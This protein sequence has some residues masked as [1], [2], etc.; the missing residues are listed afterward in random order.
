MHILTEYTSNEVFIKKSRFLTEAF[1]IKTQEKARECL[2]EQ[3]KKYQ[4]ATHVVHAFVIGES[5]EILGCSDDG[6]PSGTAGKPALAVLKGSEISN[7]MITITRWFGGTLLGTGGLVKAYGDSVKEILKLVKT[8]EFIKKASFEF[9]CTYSEYEFIKRNMQD[10]DI[11][12]TDTI[13]DAKVSISGLIPLE[14]KNTLCTFIENATKGE[15]VIFN[16]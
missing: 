3:K 14:Q 4:D 11:E 6:E 5:G 16:S 13:F 9:S 1:P 8:E 2:K 10:F 15:S 12:I 7:I